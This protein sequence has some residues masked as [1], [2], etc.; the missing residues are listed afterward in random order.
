MALKKVYRCTAIVYNCAMATINYGAWRGAEGEKY[1]PVTDE[2]I[3][4]HKDELVL[5]FLNS[6]NKNTHGCYDKLPF[7]VFHDNVKGDYT[8]PD[9]PFTDLSA[10]C[11]YLYYNQEKYGISVTRTPM[12]DNFYHPPKGSH[13]GR[14]YVITPPGHQIFDKGVKLPDE[15]KKGMKYTVDNCTGLHPDDRA[16]LKQLTK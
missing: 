16:I 5:D 1:V 13:P 10:L 15:Y 2:Y 8:N 14:V 7:Y 12:A 3:Q 9:N 4:K 11:S 6:L